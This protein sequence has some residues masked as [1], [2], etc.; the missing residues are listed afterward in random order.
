M[1]STQR[2]QWINTL[3]LSLALTLSSVSMA[4]DFQDVPMSHRDRVLGSGPINRVLSGRNVVLNGTSVLGSVMAGRSVKATNC[5]IRD[6]LSAGRDIELN[7][8]NTT[9]SISA[10]RRVALSHTTANRNVTAGSDLTLVHSIVNGNVTA[11]RVAAIENSRIGETLSVA[12]SRLVLDGSQVHN[13]QLARP[14]IA[15][16]VTG[17]Q[18]NVSINHGVISSGGGNLI[19]N[20]NRVIVSPGYGQTIAAFGSG[21]VSNLNGYTVRSLQDKTTVITPDGNV[22]INGRKVSGDGPELYSD[23]QARDPGAPRIQ[24]SGWPDNQALEENSPSSE[25]VQ[26]VELVR[27]SIVTGLVRFEGGHGKIIVYKGS[28]FEGRVEGGLVENR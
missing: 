26:I 2:A 25:P 28:R 4:S 14:E 6:S 27:N 9:E 24:G 3:L 15:M 22:Y 11:R 10:G 12:N 17:N 21:S 19:V 18:S 8:C 5:H 20:G 13:I 23:Y 1:T 16:V 7:G